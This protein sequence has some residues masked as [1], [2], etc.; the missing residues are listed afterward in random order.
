M[1]QALDPAEYPTVRVV[2]APRDTLDGPAGV[3]IW[4]FGHIED[5]P[6]LLAAWRRV[7]P[8]LLELAVA[9]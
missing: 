2:Q 4:L 6:A 7:Q 3:A 5:E 8:L 1:L 9:D